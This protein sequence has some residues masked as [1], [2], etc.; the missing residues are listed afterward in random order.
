MSKKKIMNQ[1]LSINGV[2]VVTTD[3]NN[4][5]KNIQFLPDDEFT[6]VLEEGCRNCGQLQLLRNGAFDYVSQRPRQRANSTLLRKAAHGRLSATQDEAYQ[7]TL[8][9]FKRE[10]LD[11]RATLMREA[12]ELIENVKF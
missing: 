2:S 10:G 1:T 5:V 6:P 11:V 3:E 7:L 4:K 8:K 9:I 12:T